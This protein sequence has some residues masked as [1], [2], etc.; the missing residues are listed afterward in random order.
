MTTPSQ[1][2]GSSGTV[3]QVGGTT[4]SSSGESGTSW[5]DQLAAV[6]QSANPPI[7]TDLSGWNVYC[8]IPKSFSRHYAGTIRRA[9]QIILISHQCHLPSQNLPTGGRAP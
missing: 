2:C 9:R 3:A 8:V 4:T 6:P 7:T 1:R 5:G